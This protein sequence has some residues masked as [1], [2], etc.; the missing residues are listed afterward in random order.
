MRWG[1]AK[2]NAELNSMEIFR[3]R[4]DSLFDDFFELKPST[5]F[6]KAGMPKVDVEE[7]DIKYIVKADVPG[8]DPG[9]VSVSIDGNILTISGVSVKE[10]GAE[11]VNY[12]V[13]ERF[14][15]S[16]KRTIVLDKAVN[17]EAAT[18]KYEKGVLELELPKEAG[19]ENKIKIEV[20]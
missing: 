8:Y 9:E 10:K 2:Q 5:L 15:G 14:N 4:M 11:D 6:E 3:K 18:A 20:K 19:R 12:L 1:L 7:T 17:A 13:S 16:F